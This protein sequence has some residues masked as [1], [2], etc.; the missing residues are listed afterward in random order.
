MSGTT[1]VKIKAC[2]TRRKAQENAE[3]ECRNS[4]RITEYTIC[5][6][7]RRTSKDEEKSKHNVAVDETNQRRKAKDRLPRRENTF[8]GLKGKKY[9]NLSTPKERKTRKK[10]YWVKG[11]RQIGQNKHKFSKQL[12]FFSGKGTMERCYIVLHAQNAYMDCIRH[13]GYN[14]FV[15]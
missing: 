14:V 10:R 9:K 7:E 2:T 15:L 3:V 11:Q 13:P 5:P 4:S 6:T 12:L 1:S 8:S